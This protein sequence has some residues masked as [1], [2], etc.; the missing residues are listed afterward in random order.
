[1]KKF[2]VLAAAAAVALSAA[3]Q[4]KIYVV[5]QW[6]P[7]EGDETNHWNF[8]DMITIDKTGDNFVFELD[9]LSAFKMSTKPLTQVAGEGDTMTDDW[10]EFD[11]NNY[12]CMYGFKVGEEK[13][14]FPG[15]GNI[16]APYVAKYTI[17]IAGDFS[18]VKLETS[19]PNPDGGFKVF[20][21]GGMNDWGA[22][23]DWQFTCIDE[24]NLIYE[25]VCDDTHTIA[26]ETEF[27]VA[28]A[29]WGSIN[30]GMPQNVNSETGEKV[31]FEFMPLE[32]TAAL[33]YNNGTNIKTVE[34]F[35][36][37]AYFNLNT[38]ELMLTNEDAENPFAA[39][40]N[41]TVDNNAPA[42]YYTLQGVRVSEP[43]NG[44]YIVVKDGKATKVIK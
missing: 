41:I 29:S 36:G 23:E 22:P 7:G 21:R 20:F 14:L 24:T 40:S 15:G 1:M 8:N 18:T 25:F 11:A 37:K 38:F 33:V 4:D 35:Y 27:K 19:E 26:A 16:A 32:E 44:L 43:A 17:T 39:V 28:D 34:E 12:G 2:Y 30:F 3:A 31:D 5:G 13:E 9:K 42:A 10:G 6:G